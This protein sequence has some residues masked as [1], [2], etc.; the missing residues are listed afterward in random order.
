MSQIPPPPPPPG[1]TPPPPPPPPGAMSSGAGFTPGAAIS[2]AWSATMKNLGPLVLMTLV[3]LVAQVVLQVGFSGGR[4]VVALLLSIVTSVVS[5]IL[6][7]G[8]TRAALRVTDGGTPELSQ[9]TETDQLGPYIVQAILVGI[10]IGI[11]LLLCL[12]PGLIAAV[13]FAFAGY[14]VIDGRDGDAVGAIKRSFEIVK[15]NF[16]AVLG[17]FVL[18][19]LINIV[20]ALLCGIGLLF[21][22]PMSSVAVA[23][24]YRTLNGQP[25]AA[26]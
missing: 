25:V 15:G 26:I 23:Y 13:L 19:M 24:A 22:Y 12:I 4:G 14:V 1:F 17:L 9:L 3:I 10:A 2:Y 7:M 5:L 21:T 6:A 18:L 20:G 16:G 11:G 8:L